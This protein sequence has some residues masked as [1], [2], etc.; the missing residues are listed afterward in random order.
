MNVQRR[1]ADLFLAPG[2]VAELTDDVDCTI[3]CVNGSVWIIQ[4]G[5]P[6]GIEL[7]AGEPFT[8]VRSGATIISSPRPAHLIITQAAF[9]GLAPAAR[10]AASHF[11]ILTSAGRLRGRRGIAHLW[12]VNGRAEPLREPA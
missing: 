4:Q 8:I 3:L 7:E 6:T 12:W 1:A 11:S 9:P 10:P 5:E 2:Q